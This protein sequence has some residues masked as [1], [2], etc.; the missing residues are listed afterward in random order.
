MQKNKLYIQNR[1]R[2][3]EENVG[4]FVVL[5]NTALQHSEMGM[6]GVFCHGTFACVELGFLNVIIY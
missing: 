3:K 6:S 5:R 2:K 1:S 4:G